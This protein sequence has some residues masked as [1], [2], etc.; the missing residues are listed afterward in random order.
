MISTL[1]N[2][3]QE[4]NDKLQSSSPIAKTVCKNVTFILSPVSLSVESEKHTCD[5]RC[6][7]SHTAESSQHQAKLPNPHP[8]FP[9][10]TCSYVYIF[11]HSFLQNLFLTKILITGE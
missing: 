11:L 4:S 8:A 10:L 9:L 3:L 2:E 5:V 7:T 1:F 6:S